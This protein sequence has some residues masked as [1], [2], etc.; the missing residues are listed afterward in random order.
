MFYDVLGAFLCSNLIFRS[1]MS[2]LE[3]QRQIPFE[4]F[5]LAYTP[6]TALSTEKMT[7]INTLLGLSVIPVAFNTPKE[8]QSA[9]YDNTYLAG[10]EMTFI[11][12]RSFAF[13]IRFPGQCRFG[14]D[15]PIIRNWNT[16]LNFP[17]SQYAGPRNPTDDFGGSPAGY[18]EE[19]FIAIQI[20]L[21]KVFFCNP[22]MPKIYLQVV[23]FFVS[24]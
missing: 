4:L 19:G 20:A 1:E 10:I 24:Y 2:K 16:G 17:R 22:E 12:D 18:V 11:N 3:P 9:V 23:H 6:N 14:K 21:Y 7:E 13:A 15:I 8:M 5:K